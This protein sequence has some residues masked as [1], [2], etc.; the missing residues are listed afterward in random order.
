MKEG[1]Q[2]IPAGGCQYVTLVQMSEPLWS[3]R[4]WRGFNLSRL[5]DL[6]DTVYWKAMADPNKPDLF[7]IF[8]WAKACSLFQ[9]LSIRDY[10]LL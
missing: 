4:P 3:P 8:A 9:I 2:I 10:G 5:E 6:Q 1:G 7:L